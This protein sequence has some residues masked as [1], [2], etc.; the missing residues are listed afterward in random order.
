MADA[1]VRK[2]ARRNKG[3]EGLVFLLWAYPAAWAGLE[4][5]TDGVGLDPAAALDDDRAGR[6]RNRD[7]SRTQRS[8]SQR[9]QGYRRG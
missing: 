9:R 6:L 8:R 2:E 7:A 5:G 1:D 4:I 3:F